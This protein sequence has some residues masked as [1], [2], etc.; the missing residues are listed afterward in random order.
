MQCV[1]GA[2][3][4]KSYRCTKY[5]DRSVVPRFDPQT[6]RASQVIVTFQYVTCDPRASCTLAHGILTFSVCT[7]NYPIKQI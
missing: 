1:A 6:T 4:P 7:R 2:Q 3:T 5:H